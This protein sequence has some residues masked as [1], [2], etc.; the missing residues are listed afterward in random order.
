MLIAVYR[1]PFAVNRLSGSQA[2]SQQA[3]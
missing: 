2:G 3:A 1:L